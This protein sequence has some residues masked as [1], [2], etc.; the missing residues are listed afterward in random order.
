MKFFKK[1]L[2][3]C[4]TFF[5]ISSFDLAPC[6][7]NEIQN[8]EVIVETRNQELLYAYDTIKVKNKESG[9][10][11]FL[12]SNEKKDT[13]K[14]DEIS[15][16]SLN[17]TRG[18]LVPVLELYW[19]E[20][21]E[22]VVKTKEKNFSKEYFY[23]GK[24]LKI[25]VPKKETQT[26]EVFE[27]NQLVKEVLCSGGK[28]FNDD[29]GANFVGNKLERAPF[30]GGKYYMKWW[31]RI[32]PCDITKD[33]Q[34]GNLYN[35]VHQTPNEKTLGKPASHGCIRHSSENSKEI[36]DFSYIGMPLLIMHNKADL[37]NIVDTFKYYVKQRK[38]NKNST[39]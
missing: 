14:L 21:P 13:F 12:V 34:K 37:S 6:L 24:Y 7:E 2:Y 22:L 17:N 16:D 10:E 20:M 5:M 30:I 39:K 27:G 9:L 28:Y 4:S 23:L 32:Q 1:L 29:I 31:L 15:Y 25:N 19:S 3:V 11:V 38:D 35:G 8:K 18:Y 33:K 26:T 36:Y